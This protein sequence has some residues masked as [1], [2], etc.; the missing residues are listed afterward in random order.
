LCGLDFPTDTNVLVGLTR[1]DD[2]GVYQVSDDLALIQTVDFFTPVVD[3]PYWFGQIAVANA[4]SD[5]YAMGGEPKTAMNIVS[6][7]LKQ[8]DLS[9]LRQVL[10]GGID[11]IREAGWSCWVATAWR[12]K[13]SNTG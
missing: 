1:A 3:D 13:N 6:F 4:L 8:M 12:T 11:K 5:V 7:P 10:Q 2:A 9:V